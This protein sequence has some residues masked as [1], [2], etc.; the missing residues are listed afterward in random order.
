MQWWAD[1]VGNDF[2]KLGIPREISTD[3]SSRTG[4]WLMGMEEATKHKLD[5]MKEHRWMREARLK[6]KDSKGF[7]GTHGFSGDRY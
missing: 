7:L 5:M 6:G 3:I 2:V 4:D 1:A